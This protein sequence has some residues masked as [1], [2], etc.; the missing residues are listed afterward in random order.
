MSFSRPETRM[1]NP[2]TK[3]LE[4]MGDRRGQG[5]WSYWDGDHQWTDD[6]GQDRKGKRIELTDLSMFT[7]VVLDDSLMTIGGFNKAKNCGIWSNEIP[8]VDAGKRQLTVKFFDDANTVVAKGYYKQIKDQLVAAGGKFARSVYAA[9]DAFGRMELINFKMMGAALT[10]W[11]DL[12]KMA[13][14]GTN[15]TFH[16]NWVHIP[17]I[18][19]HDDEAIP[20]VAPVFG[21]TKQLTDEDREGCFHLDE[22]LQKYLDWYLDR[23]GSE[24]RGIDPTQQELEEAT[25]PPTEQDAEELHDTSNWGAYVIQGTGIKLG[26]ESLERLQLIKKEY[27]E[28]NEFGEAYS[29]VCE[30]IRYHQSALRHGDVPPDSPENIVIDPAVEQP[31]AQTEDSVQAPASNNPFAAKPEPQPEPAP[32]PLDWKEVEIEGT[33][34]KLGVFTLDELKAGKEYCQTPAGE[35]Y[36]QY[37]EAIDA[38]IAALTEPEPSSNPFAK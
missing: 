30:G 17:E 37:E 20:F 33:G 25:A 19:R 5:G 29:N 34:R 9:T 16:G 8:A 28:M 11:F 14:R 21:F 18:A 2:A 38:G 12:A 1:R 26:D 31:V 13:E 4:W 27:E 7:F 3:F 10:P 23:G 15:G 6:K 22:K 36:K 35:S 32:A 24:E